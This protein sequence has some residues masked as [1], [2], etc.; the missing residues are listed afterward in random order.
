MLLAVDVGNTHTVLGLFEGA[1]TRAE[2]RIATR[3]EETAD[4]LDG[5]LAGLLARRGLDFEVIEAG[6]VS[7][8]VPPL[9]PEWAAT[10]ERLCGRPPVV[11]GPGVR[12][13]M[14]LRTETPAEVGPDRIANAVAAYERTRSACVVVDFGTSTNFD[15]VSR[16]GE[17]LGGAIAPGVDIS[18]EALFARAARLTKVALAA[19]PS[20]IGRSTVASM[21]SGAVYGFAG[22]VDGIVKRI[23]GELGGP[24]PTIGTGG[25]AR[26]IA[27][28]TDTISDTDSRLT[29][30]GLRILWDRNA[31]P[32]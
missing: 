22:L 5:Q 21:Q 12:T 9:G 27:P 2:W 10:L 20:A 11:V 3:P 28:H 31:A 4:E 25:L 18:M 13:G 15:V 32:H 1:E 23:W 6:C 24:V 26:L 16:A 17:F 8:T 7:S 14:P 19:P 29:L 30:H